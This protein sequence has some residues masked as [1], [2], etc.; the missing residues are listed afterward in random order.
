MTK[1]VAVV[2]VATPN[3]IFQQG[4]VLRKHPNVKQKA[5]KCGRDNGDD[6]AE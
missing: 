5:K 2:T 6:G 4:R 3:F 1:G